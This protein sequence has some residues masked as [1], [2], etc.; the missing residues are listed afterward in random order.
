[1]MIQTNNI[2]KISTN[3]L[4]HEQLHSLQ[5]TRKSASDISNREISLSLNNR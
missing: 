4:E 3:D 5:K 2:K 1:M